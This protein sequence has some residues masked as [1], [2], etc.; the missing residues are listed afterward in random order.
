MRTVLWL[1]SFSKWNCLGRSR[2]YGLGRDV[3][4]GESLKSQETSAIPSVISLPPAYRSSVP[5]VIPSLH[6]DG[7]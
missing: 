1:T 4:L 6:Y 3:L 7:L 2:R 5:A